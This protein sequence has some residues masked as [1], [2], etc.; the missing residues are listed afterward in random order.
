M[1]TYKKEKSF[2]ESFIKDLQKN[3]KQYE[4]TLSDDE[5]LEEDY[6][7]G[8]KKISLPLY[9]EKFFLKTLIIKSESVLTK[10]ISLK[11][12][13]KF[14]EH[15]SKKDFFKQIQKLNSINRKLDRKITEKE[16]IRIDQDYIITQSTFFLD[17]LK[18]LEKVSK[19][20]VSFFIV[21][22][23]GVGK[24]FLAKHVHF[25]SERKNYKVEVVT[26]TD[27]LVEDILFGTAEPLL[28]KINGGTLVIENAD[29]LNTSVQK[30][31]G[32]LGSNPKIFSQ[33]KNDFISIDV[34][35]IFTTTKVDFNKYFDEDLLFNYKSFAL[36]VPSFRQR[37]EDIKLLSEY[38]LNQHL[39]LNEK[40]V[41]TDSGIK[42]LEE[43][44]WPGNITELKKIMKEVVL[45]VKE[46]Y[47]D[48]DILQNFFQNNKEENSLE[49]FEVKSLWEVER[50]IILKTL[51]YFKGNKSHAAKALGVTIKTLYNKIQ[52]YGE[53]LNFKL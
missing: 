40:K 16:K 53:N 12:K 44:N 33:K 3:F 20:N 34:N 42:F 18:I 30:K 6:S 5:I 27:L 9:Y 13:K 15:K 23:K 14:E 24:T 29:F 45:T 21:G 2:F 37:K 11:I 22:E 36:K 51:M 38:F 39:D 28:E 47:V 52:E 50:E 10:D 35:I 41:I 43:Y 48:K 19:E 31:I 4:F 32:N 25:L 17:F 8:R 46:T 49:N 26:G 7:I 1:S